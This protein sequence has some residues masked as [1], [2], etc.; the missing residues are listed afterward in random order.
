[1]LQT[2]RAMQP[3]QPDMTR[4]NDQAYVQSYMNDRMA[5]E[6]K[7]A[8]LAKAFHD[9]FPADPANAEL[10]PQRWMI[11]LQTGQ[12]EVVVAETKAALDAK[13]AGPALADLLF[14]RSVALIETNSDDAAATVD[15]FIAAAPTDE[16]GAELLGHEHVTDPA[17]QLAIDQRIVQLYP[18]S[19]AA[20][21]AQGAIR[22]MQS[23]GKPFELDFTDAITGKPISLQKDLKGK[24]VVI[25]FW[26]TWCGP[27]VGEMPENKAT[28]AKFK[29]Q[30]VE[31]IGVSLDQP[32]AKGGLKALKDFVATNGITWPQYYQGNYW[33]SDFSSKW[34][35][36]SIP[37]MFLVD[38][39]GNL[40]STDARGQLEDL[41]PKLIAKRDHK[42]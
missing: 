10:M 37:T 23:I 11:L 19:D 15:Q 39:D 29:N 7:R 20:T 38:A 33:Q 21:E 5:F 35:I 24:I 3:P 26:A 2:F 30:G 41:I 36:T 4:V 17:K 9:K 18:K 8:A 6:L 32:E 22:Q 28:Y 25:D 12:P 27:C 40:S 42:Q 14:V 13:P 31:F 1:M 16:R 34:G